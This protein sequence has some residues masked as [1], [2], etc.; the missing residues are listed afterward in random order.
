MKAIHEG[1]AGARAHAEEPL[2]GGPIGGHVA[3]VQGYQDDVPWMERLD[4][5]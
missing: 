5:S 4:S 2:H 1:L 3:F